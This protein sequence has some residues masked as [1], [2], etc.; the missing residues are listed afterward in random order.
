[1]ELRASAGHPPLAWVLVSPRLLHMRIGVEVAA[2]TLQSAQ[3]QALH[4]VV[5]V[6]VLRVEGLGKKRVRRGKPGVTGHRQ[7]LTIISQ[8]SA[9]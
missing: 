6:F 3:Q 7:M 5:A 4:G 8:P 9:W 1:M 2:S